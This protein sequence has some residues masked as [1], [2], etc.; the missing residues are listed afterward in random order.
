[1]PAYDTGAW[2][3]YST[4]SSR[5]ESDVSYHELLRDFLVSMC[6]RTQATV[7]CGTADRFTEYETEPPKLDIAAQKLRG[8]RTGTL[9]VRLSK[10][11][12]VTVEIRRG[13]SVVMSRA[14]GTVPYG[15]VRIPW[16]VPRRKGTYDISVR[17]RD[18]KG[19][20]ADDA[21]TVDVLKPVR[22]RKRRA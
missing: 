10:I 15:L 12:S 20:T 5:H 18:L 7:Y 21:G 8:G 4:G 3:L 1:V 14:L 17:A 19:N 22:K 6:D 16:T 9:R 13:D 11:S 2:S